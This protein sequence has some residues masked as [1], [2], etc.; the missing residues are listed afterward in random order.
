[1]RSI[2]RNNLRAELFDSLM[3]FSHTLAHA[4]TN[5]A[6]SKRGWLSSQKTGE[7][8]FR[9]TESWDEAQE[10]MVNGYPDGL[11]AIL[12]AEGAVKATK[13]FCNEDR[14]DFMGYRPN[15]QRY[16][17]GLPNCM[18]RRINE[19]PKA[20]VI[21]LFYDAGAGGGTGAE[22]LA[23]AGR[24]LM[25]L[26]QYYEKS[27]IHVNLSVL[28]G[29]VDIDTNR[30]TLVAVKI[31]DARQKLNP[32]LVSY[33]MTHPS[34]FRR[35]IFRWI[36]T[37]KCTDTP[38]FAMNYGAVLRDTVECIHN[39]SMTDYLRKHGVMGKN[40]Y[41]IDCESVAKAKTLQDVIDLIR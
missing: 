15:V 14:N 30:E 34:F 20:S 8:E 3:E 27:N 35:H 6:F 37:S 40:G 5:G 38:R 19:R 32:L 9:G 16:L 12:N 18:I 29:G 11:K 2:S 24:N 21:D 26:V 1:M 7:T 41:Y 31:K 13:A 28:D 22:K 36:E 33:P 4:P 25:T 17:Q 39:G 10:L 23:R